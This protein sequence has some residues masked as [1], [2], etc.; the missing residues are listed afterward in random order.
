MVVLITDGISDALPNLPEVIASQSQ[1]NVRRMADGVLAA[2][3]R[4]GVRDDMSVLVARIIER[5]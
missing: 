3:A 5:S 2:A 1:V 4:S